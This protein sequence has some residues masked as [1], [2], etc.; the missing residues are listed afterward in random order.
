M[1]NT[2]KTYATPLLI[3]HGTIESVTRAASSQVPEASRAPLDA[4]Y[5]ASSFCEPNSFAPSEACAS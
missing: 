2:K 3:V 5:P 1:Q 4:V